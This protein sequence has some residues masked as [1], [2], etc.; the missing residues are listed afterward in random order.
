MYIKMIYCR[1]L[2]QTAERQKDKRKTKMNSKWF[3]AWEV[4]T[5][6]LTVLF[7]EFDEDETVWRGEDGSYAVGDIMDF[8]WYS[9][10]ED[11]TEY[12]DAGTVG[13]YMNDE[14]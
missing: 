12:H 10:D 7:A 11:A 2:R 9:D 4:T 3:S 13:D 5:Q 6:G 1:Q 14:F 8:E